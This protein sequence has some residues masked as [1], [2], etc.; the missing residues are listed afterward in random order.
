MVVRRDRLFR[1][2]TVFQA[3]PGTQSEVSRKSGFSKQSVARALQE[4]VAA[5]QAHAS[6][7]VFVSNGYTPYFSKGKA[8]HGF[9]LGPRPHKPDSK[10][11]RQ[12]RYRT[13]AKGRARERAR[14]DPAKRRAKY[15]KSKERTLAQKRAAWKSRQAKRVTPLGQIAATLARA[16]P[17]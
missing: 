5:K 16:A 14:Y 17:A 10:L 6:E 3:L 1:N 13:S 7:W 9:E 4:L 15:L 8:P 2:E 11:E 12:R